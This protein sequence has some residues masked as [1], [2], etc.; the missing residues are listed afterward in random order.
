MNYIKIGVRCWMHIIKT[1][2]TLRFVQR[3]KDTLCVLKPKLNPVIR[4]QRSEIRKTFNKR[5]SEK[6]RSDENPREQNIENR[7]RRSE[8]R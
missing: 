3:I 2:P 1:R 8:I 5:E 6:D 4:D 7:D